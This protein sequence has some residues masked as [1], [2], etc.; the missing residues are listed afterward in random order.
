MN[1]DPQLGASRAAVTASTAM[2]ALD[3][4]LHAAASQTPPPPMP[5]TD[6]LAMLEVTATAAPSSA[7]GLTSLQ[8]LRDAVFTAAGCDRAMQLLWS[9]ALVTAAAARQLAC[10]LQVPAGAAA[11]AGLL[12]RIGA[13]RL[14]VIIAQTETPAL[15]AHAALRR[16][17]AAAHELALRD[18][19]LVAWAVPAASAHAARNWSAAS[20]AAVANK[21]CQ[22]VYLAQ[23]LKTEFLY[24][25]FCV[26]QM[27]NR[28]A[29]QFGVTSA[30]LRAAR[31][32]KSDFG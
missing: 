12:H 29:R 10:A 22:V 6:L 27:A 16:Q 8:P 3:G 18:A 17:L 5:M 13:A 21:M 19:L 28:V 24:P 11:L 25:Q 20:S 30:S 23:L 14:L 7:S 32:A 2:Q 31:N 4:A 26:P 1:Q 9:E 15:R